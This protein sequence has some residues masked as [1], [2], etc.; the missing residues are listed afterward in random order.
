LN[1]ASR[2]EDTEY[3]KLTIEYRLIRKWRDWTN[4]KRI[5]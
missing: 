5:K 1:Q 2:I 3:S 4:V